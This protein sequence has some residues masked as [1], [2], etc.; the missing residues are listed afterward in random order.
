MMNDHAAKPVMS[1]LVCNGTHCVVVAVDGSFEVRLVRDGSLIRFE[2][3]ALPGPAFE[4]AHSWRRTYSAAPMVSADTQADTQ[5][6][7][8]LAK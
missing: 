8:S 6:D 7:T 2:R 5:L 4:T 3:F 1:W